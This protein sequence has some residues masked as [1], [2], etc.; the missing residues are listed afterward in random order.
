MEKEKAGYWSGK[1]HGRHAHARGSCFKTAPEPCTTITVFGFRSPYGKLTTASLLSPV[2]AGEKGPFPGHPAENRRGR[3]TRAKRASRLHKNCEV[4]G[5]RTRRATEKVVAPGNGTNRR[6]IGPAAAGHRFPIRSLSRC[7]AAP[8]PGVITFRDMKRRGTTM[9][10]RVQSRCAM[11]SSSVAGCWAWR[12]A[13]RIEAA[14]PC[15]SP[16]HN[17]PKR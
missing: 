3:G 10:K 2:L 16:W 12:R 6:N 8:L 13:K 17:F 15:T 9:I 14:R 7:R 1:W 11:P 4:T 5:D